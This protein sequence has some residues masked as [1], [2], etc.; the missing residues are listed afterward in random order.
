MQAF[1]E[2]TFYCQAYFNPLQYI[3]LSFLAEPFCLLTSRLLVPFITEELRVEQVRGGHRGLAVGH[4]SA[5]RTLPLA[6]RVPY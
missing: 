5:G 2:T 6:V 1:G 3:L 4:V